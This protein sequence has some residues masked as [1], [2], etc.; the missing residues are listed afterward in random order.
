MMI[1]VHFLPSSYN[2]VYMAILQKL[3]YSHVRKGQY[4]LGDFAR[5]SR[6][7]RTN[8]SSNL[9]NAGARARST[10]PTR[11]TYRPPHICQTRM[12]RLFCG[13]IW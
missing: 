12:C 9:R 2:V 7:R 13:P 6:R 10:I 4:G 8:S 5:L 1:R 11:S 3:K